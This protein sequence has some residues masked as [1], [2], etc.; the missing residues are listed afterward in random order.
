MPANEPVARD[1]EQAGIR[2]DAGFE[3]GREP[4]GDQLGM[5]ARHR[6]HAVRRHVERHQRDMG[7]RVAVAHRPPVGARTLA[8]SSR[9]IERNRRRPARLRPKPQTWRIEKRSDATCTA[10]APASK[11]PMRAAVT[12][13]LAPSRSSASSS[14]GA[15]PQQRQRHRDHAGAQHAEDGQHAL[16]GVGERNADDGV[17]RQAEPRAAATAI[18]ATARSACA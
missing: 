8:P 2:L 17:G 9:S 5:V 4:A 7:R 15:P 11:S 18:A 10:I 13:A 1:A 6:D 12:I 3:H 14:L 16:D